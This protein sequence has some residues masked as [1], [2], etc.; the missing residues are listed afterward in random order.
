MII[1]AGHFCLILTFFTA[2]LT[3]ALPYFSLPFESIL[4]TIFRSVLLQTLLLIMSFL[5]LIY[6]FYISDFSLLLAFK[7]S[8]LKQPL[9]Y[10]ISAIIGNH[11]GS[12]L[13]WILVVSFLGTLFAYLHSSLSIKAPFIY[14]KVLSFQSLLVA[15]FSGFALIASNPFL[16]TTPLSSGLGL[17][18]LLQDPS[19]ALHPPSLYLGFVGFAP[20]FSIG[21][22]ILSEK[23]V[24]FSS[25]LLLRAWSLMAWGFLT[26]GITLGSFWAYYELGW[27]GWWFWDPVET[28][29]L[30]PWVAGLILIHL[31]SPSI[32]TP[33]LKT[34]LFFSL[35]PFA[36]SLLG[37]LFIR[38]GL[39]LSVHS[40][41]VDPY[42][43]FLMLLIWSVLLGGAFILYF[44]NA[45]KI[46]LLETSPLLF[47][48]KETLILSGCVLLTIL[49]ITLLIGTIAPLFFELL[50]NMKISIGAPY[51][52]TLAL[53]FS[54]LLTLLITLTIRLK[55][56]ASLLSLKELKSH[57]GF[58]FLFF[59]TLTLSLYSFFNFIPELAFSV[60]LAMTLLLS[61][62][63]LSFKSFATKAGHIG[64]A[65]LIGGI[66]LD[67]YLR[68]E[69][70]FLV[71]E[72]STFTLSPFTFHFKE[73]LSSSANNYE[74]IKAHIDVSKEGL[75]H[76]QLIPSRRFYV[77]PY[78]EVTE[79][80]LS[81]NLRQT[82]YTLLGPQQKDGSWTLK[83]AIHPFV[84]F[85]WLG[86]LFMALSG[87]LK[88]LLLLRPKR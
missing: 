25:L 40:F 36:L 35:F 72:G 49:L 47:P 2:L 52:N 11:E 4:K 37:T 12:F 6:T 20:P 22:A 3:F 15:L 85:I 77:A 27:G 81:L 17:N 26:L 62:L 50:Q 69:Q 46:R 80:S 66:A 23:K 24:L 51:F 30:L 31:L 44:K 70:T 53:P 9:L 60:A 58:M 39:L 33:P 29:S 45:P 54:F 56:P 48:T 7:H 68:Q 32:K 87:L 57:L 63:P 16:R 42:K 65:L 13:V 67:T 71:K 76:T 84:S 55:N 21:L 41:A 38:S 28:I 34:V 82:L 79:T 73:V 5:S 88:A 86:G 64:L 59:I 83:V 18:P 75:F 78:K 1:E 14:A 43:G 10:K 8:H 61:H 19:L 74:E